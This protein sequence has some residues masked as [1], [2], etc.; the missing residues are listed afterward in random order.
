[1]DYT[2]NKWAV[3]LTCENFV[4]NVVVSKKQNEIIQGSIQYLE[5]IC[6]L[7]RKVVHGEKKVFEDDV[8]VC[9]LRII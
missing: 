6:S 3:H 7:S 1:M 4:E 9:I 8:L 5:R 2:S